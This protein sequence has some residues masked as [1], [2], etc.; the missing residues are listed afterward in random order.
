[1]FVYQLSG[2]GFK[3]RC[4]HLKSFC[5]EIFQNEKYGI[6]WDKKLMERWYLLITEKFL[7]LLSVDE[8]Y[9]LFW[10]KKLMEKIIFTDYWKSFVLH[11]PMMRNM[12]F[13]WVKKLMGKIILTDYRKLFGGG[14]YSLFSAKKWMERWYLQVTEKLLFWNF[15]WWEMRSFFSQKVDGKIIFIWSFW[16]FHEISRRSGKYSFSCWDN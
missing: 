5:F 15:P 11:F 6:V 9:G 13:F 3:S 1:M 16:A 8:N 10:A 2:C 14:K 7:L 12:V 4:S